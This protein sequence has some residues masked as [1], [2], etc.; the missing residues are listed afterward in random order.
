MD[1]VYAVVKEPDG[2]LWSDAFTDWQAV[3]DYCSELNSREDNPNAYSI[4]ALSVI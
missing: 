1:Q 4:R 3:N 2:I